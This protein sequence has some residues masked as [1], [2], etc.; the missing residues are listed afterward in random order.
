MH[1]QDDGRSIVRR[2][3]VC[4]CRDDFPEV[5]I[6]INLLARRFQN[7][8]PPKTRNKRVISE[9][10]CAVRPAV[11]VLNNNINCTKFK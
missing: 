10:R 9:Q 11:F 7:V 5:F 1:G 3:C 4:V 8:L 2:V 6:K